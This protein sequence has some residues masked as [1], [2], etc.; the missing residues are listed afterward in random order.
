MEI[1]PRQP[2]ETAD[3]SRGKVTAGD[4]IKTLIGVLVFLVGLY[5]VLGW[6]GILIGNTIPD[7]WERKLSSTSI[8]EHKDGGSLERPQRLLD[9]LV[10]GKE[11]RDLDYRLFWVAMD[12][13]N[14]R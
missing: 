10:K 11:L 14:K 6:L 13:P 8:L 12:V 3:N 5:L 7:R 1:V 2:V 4:A 9:R